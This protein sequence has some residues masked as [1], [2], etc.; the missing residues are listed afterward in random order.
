MQS[1]NVELFTKCVGF[2]M[3]MSRWG[4]SRKADLNKITT[5]SDKTMLKLSKKLIVAK[6][7]DDIVSHMGHTMRHIERLAVP[8]FFKRGFYLIGNDAVPQVESYLTGRLDELK[9]LALKLAEVYP[10]KVEEAGDRLQDEWSAND[11]PGV[12]KLVSM[13]NMRWNF[14][15]FGI[16]ESLPQELFE[17]ERQRQEQIWAEAG[18]QITQCLRSGFLK[19]VEVAKTQ[20]V[21]EPGEKKKK[22]HDSM[23][24]NILEFAEMFRHRNITNDTELEKLVNKAQEIL[25]GI[26][27]DDLRKSDDMKIQMQ[28]EFAGISEQLTSLIETTPTRSF[29]FEEE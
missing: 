12:Q 24:G 27:P 29:D 5:T 8:S 14:V 23:I 26:K 15:A 4:N 28:Q 11:Y 17:I 13:F 1:V 7:Y 16:P 10:A 25:T 18:D 22:I 3:T 19:L 21:V 20:L 6:E 2:T 9:Q